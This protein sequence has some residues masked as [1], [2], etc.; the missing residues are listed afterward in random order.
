VNAA[1]VHIVVLNW[2]R[3]D[4]TIACVESLRAAE[5]GG[6]SVMVVDNGSRD[7]SV[8]ALRA[9]FPDLR[10]LELPENRGYAGG[11][12]AGIRAALD[13]GAE[14]V[15]L[16]NNDTRVAPDF[17]GP[18]LQAMNASPW[19]GAV[20]AAILRMDNP[21][22]LDV[23]Y[24][25]I[26]FGKRFVVQIRGVN[27]LV[28]EGFDRRREVPVAIGCCLLLKAEALRNVG[29]FDEAYF[30]YHEDVDWC[31]RARIAGYQLFYEPFARI[32][33][34]GSGTTGAIQERP[35]A[36]LEMLP[37]PALP[38]AEPL[39]WNPVRTYL[40]ARN[41]VRLLR[42]HATR[43][44]AIRFA[45]ACCRELPLEFMAA[46][47]NREG[48]LR[49]GRWSYG[50]TVRYYFRDRH[51]MLR[52]RSRGAVDR[53]RRFL[54]YCVTFPVDLLW[55]LPRDVVRASREGRIA[56]VMADV[57][58]LRDGVL[59]RPVPFAALGLRWGVRSRGHAQGRHRFREP[60]TVPGRR[61]GVSYD[62]AR[63]APS[64]HAQAAGGSTPA[65][66]GTAASGRRDRVDRR[67]SPPAHAAC[68]G[69]RR[70]TRRAGRPGR[71]P[72]VPWAGGDR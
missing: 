16:L 47:L 41:V 11:N 62:G 10:V 37:E 61:E 57:R 15:L 23:A 63:P 60:I 49:L 9:R 59:D 7:G 67:E 70:R 13:A 25:E 42:S 48:W 26:D 43:A 6:A 1:G 66:P 30:A 71:M 14:G 17:L 44:Q 12:N 36:T 46:V 35:E 72:A 51:P 32:F 33:H 52:R 56:S 28:G 21:E 34:R 2:N 58:G 29:L 69:P 64:R 68:S 5:L 19:T 65:P 24:S 55:S 8:A 38:N 54:V 53:V 40:G 45:I 20:S 39:Q 31:I 4:D 3:R 18:L 50:D 22:M 27:A